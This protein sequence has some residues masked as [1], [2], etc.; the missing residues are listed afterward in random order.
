MHNGRGEFS[1]GGGISLGLELAAVT[2]ESDALFERCIQTA[3]DL[4]QEGAQLGGPP[5]P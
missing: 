1:Q 5:L 2:S 4:D 3:N